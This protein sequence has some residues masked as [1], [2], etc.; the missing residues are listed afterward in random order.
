MLG[1]GAPFYGREAKLH[2]NSWFQRVV[3]GVAAIAAIVTV[4]G[5]AAA[6][7]DGNET[8]VITQAAVRGSGDVWSA[9]GLFTDGGGWYRG[10][11]YQGTGPNTFEAHRFTTEY[12]SLGAFRIDLQIHRNLVTETGVYG[13]WVIDAGTA[14]DAPTGAYVGLHGQGTFTSTRD[15]LTG[16]RTYTLVG[17]V[18]F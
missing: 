15:A 7:T 12:G 18:H 9:S 13:T 14:P 4:S 3:V 11:S 1:D 2:R 10:V 5:V 6:S 17:D 16:A 8:I